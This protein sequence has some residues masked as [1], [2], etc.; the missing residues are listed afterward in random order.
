MSSKCPACGFENIPGEDRCAECLISLMQ[1]DL[2]RPKKDDAI[3]KAMMTNPVSEIVTGRD[4]L[5]AKEGDSILK[6][7]KILQ[8]KK[9][10]CVLIYQKKKLI[11]IFCPTFAGQ[12]GTSVVKSTRLRRT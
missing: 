4:L 12:A 9:L 6:I 3:Q 8:D 1:R 10:D 11:G 2:P 5:V 7:V